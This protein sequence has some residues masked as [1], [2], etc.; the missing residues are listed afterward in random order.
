MKAVQSGS[1]VESVASVLYCLVALVIIAS[2]LLVHLMGYGFFFFTPE[3]LALGAQSFSFP[4]LVFFLVGF[5]MPIPLRVSMVFSV[6]W[7]LYVVC[8]I[9][10][11]KWRE[12]FHQAW[13]RV[14]SGKSKNV[15]SNFLFAMPLLSSM[16]LTAAL[17]IILSQSAVGVSTGEVQLPSDLHEAF[18]DLAYGPLI[19]EL[20]FRLVPIGLVMVFYVFA[21]ARNVKAVSVAGNRLKLFC[22]AFIYPE[23]AKKM[24]GL[25]QVGV[26]GLWKGISSLEWVVIVITSAVFAFAHVLSPIGWEMG[27]ITSAFVQGLFLA[28][29]YVAYGFEAP[30]LLHWFT[31][32]YFFF[33]DPAVAEKFF[34]ATVDLLSWIE[35]LILVLGV[36]GWAVFATRLF[37]RL[38][39][40]RRQPAPPPPSMPSI[41]PSQSP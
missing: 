4:V 23:E 33:F 34:P 38:L 2:F 26:Q 9:A 19:E 21:A 31:N 35:I 12:S 39:R 6:I 17:A 7:I 24:S 36:V 32:Y 22:L 27:K 30:V 18:L 11:W 16:A 1:S 40:L 3:G 28:V 13:R 5:Y 15:L 10:A 29:T 41:S 8:F 20:A 25:P 37:G 14:F